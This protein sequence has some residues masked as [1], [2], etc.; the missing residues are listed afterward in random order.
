M[1]LSPNRYMS[2]K[3]SSIVQVANVAHLTLIERSR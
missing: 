2:L 1:I 3:E